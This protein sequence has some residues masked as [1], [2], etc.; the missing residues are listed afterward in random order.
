[1]V[2]KE[3]LIQSSKGQSHSKITAT[4]ITNMSKSTNKKQLQKLQ[5]QAIRKTNQEKM[6]K[7]CSQQFISTEKY[8]L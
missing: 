3:V 7:N 1:M 4:K 8:I 5:I 2:S 6:V